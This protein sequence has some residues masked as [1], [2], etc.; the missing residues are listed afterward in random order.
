MKKIFLTIAIFLII[1]IYGLYVKR[2]L[3][4]RLLEPVM[5]LPITPKNSVFAFDLHGV[6]LTPNN[7]KLRTLCWE[8]FFMVAPWRLIFNPKVWYHFYTLPKHASSSKIKLDILSTK[9]PEFQHLK[10]FCNELMVC[11]DL[12]Y[13][14]IELIKKLKRKGYGIYILSDI[15]EE[16]LAQLQQKHT[17]LQDLFDGQFTPNV[18]NHEYSKPQDEFYRAFKEYINQTSDRNKQ[19]IFIDNAFKNIIGAENNGIEGVHFH[20]AHQ[21]K[22]FLKMLSE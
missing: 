1:F 17:E 6:V 10:E 5:V 18:L 8:K 7:E 21:L 3:L 12:N 13:D 9:Y 11:Y 2:H 20:S 19:I 16:P 14:T 22:K 15:W 4:I